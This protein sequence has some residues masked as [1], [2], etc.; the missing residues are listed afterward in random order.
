METNHTILIVDD[1]PGFRKTL[2]DI[3]RIKGYNAF[4]VERGQAALDQI[5][6]E[7]PALALIDLKLED[8]SGLELMGAIKREFP[9]TECILL[10]GYASQSSAIEA[11][12]LGAY[13]YL[14]KP[15]PVDQLLV[16]IQRAIERQ[17][18]EAT[19]RRVTEQRQRLLQIAQ[20]MLATLAFDEVIEQVARNLQE[21]LIF[22]AFGLYWFDEEAGALCPLVTS[23]P[24]SLLPPTLG[25]NIFLNEDLL[26]AMAWSEQ[27]ELINDAHLDPRTRHPD[28]TATVETHVICL[29]LRAKAKIIGVIFV[30][31]GAAGPFTSE[32][33]ESLQLFNSY[34]SLALANARLFEQTTLSEKRYR[35]LFEESKDAIVIVSPEGKFIEV[36]S[37][38]VELLGYDAV[39]ELLQSD[40]FQYLNNTPD[41]DKFTQTLAQQGFIKDFEFTLRKKDGQKVTVLGTAMAM[42]N[43]AGE[44]AAYQA[45]VRDITER[46]HL[47]EQLRQSQKMEAVGRLAGGI[48]HDFNNLL[49]VITGYTGLLLD[50]FADE[51]DSHRKDIEQI[52]QAA[53]RAASLTRQLLTFSR[54]QVLQ[55]TVLNLNEVL[56]NLEKMLRRLINED[57]D[58]VTVLGKGLG[59]VKA[60]PGQMEQVILN[61]A[62]NARDAMPKGGKLTIETANVE[63]DYAYA[64]RYVGVIPGRYVLL[65]VSDTGAGMNEETQSHIFEPFF[66]T[67]ALGQGTGLGLATVHGIVNQSNGHIWVYSEPGHGTLFKVY[68]PR[69]DETTEPIEGGPASPQ[70]VPATETILLV[71][72]NDLVRELADIILRRN[73]YSTLL[74]SHG[75][76]AIQLSQQHQEDIHLLLTD[77]VMPGGMGGRQL[78]EYLAPLRPTMK[79]LYMSGY[80]DDAIVHHGVLDWGKAFL[81]KPFTPAMLVSKVREVLDTE[82]DRG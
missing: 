20:A 70:P 48:A 18:A 26:R 45:I 60:D 71:E 3:L 75:A 66:T 74:A 40:L 19:L 52:N 73:G 51:E 28:G 38:A 54:Q 55:P 27:G 64:R 7:R 46:K 2:S 34:V 59:Q 22:D 63:L 79:V 58:L 23:D 81:Q 43:E 57:I 16:M 42:Y 9:S 10:T 32:E 29:P 33:F 30:S 69:V 49:T 41:L 15:Y 14:Q 36:N 68:L 80:T 12:N 50:K 61:L 11:V 4:G 62:I 56:S 47:E 37:A 77:V 67:K 31:R 35:T 6:R 78:A 82:P 21:L 44:I 65:T 39:E 53:K 5:R 72:D 17:E 25:E 8:M 13:G 24:T 1:D 76:E